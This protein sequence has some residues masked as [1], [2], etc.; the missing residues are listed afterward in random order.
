MERFIQASRF[1]AHMNEAL[2]VAPG[3]TGEQILLRPDG[4]VGKHGHGQLAL[5]MG[6]SREFVWAV[7]GIDYVL[8]G[9]CADRPYPETF[10]TPL[11]HDA[12]PMGICIRYSDEPEDAPKRS[13][14]H[15]VLA[16]D[17]MQGVCRIVVY[18]ECCGSY[19]KEYTDRIRRLFPK[20]D[21]IFAA[22][23]DLYDNS[24]SHP[25]WIVRAFVKAS[26]IR[27]A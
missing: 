23:P 17:D 26:I 9:P 5:P 2:I 15:E 1:L 8:E 10:S 16:A 14:I 7:D 12:Y 18:A 20:I 6:P 25:D 24:Y 3:A 27:I 13:W 22:V 4:Q 21:W 19:T 11:D